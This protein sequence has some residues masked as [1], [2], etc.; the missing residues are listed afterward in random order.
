MNISEITEKEDWENFVTK[1]DTDS[2]L[3]SWNW[4]EFNKNTGEKI[5]RL[6]FFQEKNL[7]AVALVIKVKARRGTFLFVPHGPVVDSEQSKK[8]T[9]GELKSF[10]TVLGKKEGAA[11]IRISPIFKSNEENLAIFKKAGFKNA[12]IHMMHPETTW[13][14]NIDKDE[15]NLLS[16]MKKNHRNL[17]RRAGKEGVEIIQGDSEEFLKS[18]YKIHME[19][20]RRHHFVPFSYEYIKQELETFK[21]DGQISIFNARY[22]NKIISSAIIVFYGNE[23]FYHHGASSSE[24]T[25]IPSSYLALFTAIQEAQKRGIKKFNFYGIVD[26]KPRHPWFGLSKFKKGFG[27]EEMSLVHCQ[28]LP[29]NSRYRL[30]YL[31]ETLRKIKRGY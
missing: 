17:I 5:W 9:I 2:F 24:H 20:V 19:T 15:A 22:E 26:N 10:L 4:G 12:P 3:H 31:V 28:D 16:E 7:V 18:F 8:E 27:G 29:L 14:L 1:N 13:I 21:K 30:T 23:A 6:G 25:K 11:F